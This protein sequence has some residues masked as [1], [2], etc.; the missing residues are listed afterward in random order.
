MSDE[1]LIV[2]LGEIGASFGLALA[3]FGLEVTRVGHDPDKRLA[4]AAK[5]MGAVDRL[6]SNPARAVASAGLVILSAPPDEA[7]IYLE[8]MF[9]RMQPGTLVV[10]TSPAR[11]EAT[12]WALEHLPESCAY[13]GAMPVV[14]HHGL[15]ESPTVPLTPSA[16][17]FRGG[18]LALAI[19]SQTPERAVNMAI[20]LA[21]VL[22]AE[23][24]F[25]EPGEADAVLAAV[26]GLPVLAGVALMRL[27]AA[28]R[29]WRD[30]QRMAGLPFAATTALV[31]RQDPGA[32]G[33][34]LSMNRERLLAGLEDLI[35][36]L[37]ALRDLLAQE[38]EELLLD[39]LRETAAARTTWL[40]RREQGEWT[41]QGADT[42]S[43]P[44]GTLLDNLLG[45][46]PKRR[47]MKK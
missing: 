9:P 44:V 12:A 45:I 38:D 24:Y 36:E 22:G 20:N 10:D 32:L 31:T 5:K 6:E 23:P 7:R 28:S 1:V 18:L 21:R 40:Q 37:N 42:K 47:R 34:S 30:I 27:A 4:R 11:Q 46:D 16:D 25:I 3:Q 19:P 29:G 14:N 2:G 15:Q 8:R 26:E 43:I 13:V 39:L 35:R 17:L 41:P 33:A